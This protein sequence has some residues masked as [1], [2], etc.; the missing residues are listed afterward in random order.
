MQ[1]CQ[2]RGMWGATS[3]CALGVN[4]TMGL[5]VTVGHDAEN[6]GEN[7]ATGLTS[8]DLT[9]LRAHGRHRPQKKGRASN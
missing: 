1:G 7:L 2:V 9:E 6:T 3:S 4:L 8:M 5:D